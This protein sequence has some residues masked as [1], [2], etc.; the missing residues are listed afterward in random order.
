MQMANADGSSPSEGIDMTRSHIIL[1]PIPVEAGQR[2]CP[3]GC[4]GRDAMYIDFCQAFGDGRCNSS[5]GW[6]RCAACHAAEVAVPE[7]APECE[8]CGSP[9][10]IP[11]R[12][13][14]DCRG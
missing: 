10:T 8:G 4:H 13:C 6:L 5:N 7:P 2:E 3:V 9:V 12:W 1:P 14:V 11:G